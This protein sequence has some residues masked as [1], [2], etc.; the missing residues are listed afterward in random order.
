M[1]VAGSGGREVA[2]DL[3]ADLPGGSHVI[4]TKDLAET[5]RNL[6]CSVLRTVEQL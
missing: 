6:F 2:G 5:M 4:L 3:A 1:M